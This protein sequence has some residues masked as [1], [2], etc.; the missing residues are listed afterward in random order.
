MAVST[1]K[2]S[3]GDVVKHRHFNFR[4]VIYDVDFEFN[5]S[6][7]WYRS[8]PKDV[9]PRKDQPFYHLLAENNDI[10][11]ERDAFY[12][13]SKIYEREGNLTAAYNNFKAYEGLKEKTDNANTA[14]Q[15][16]RLESRLAIELKEKE[17]QIL[18]LNQE[19][20]K[21]V[22]R[23]QRALNYAL[24]VIVLLVLL[25]LVMLFFTA[26]KRRRQNR[27]LLLKN[28]QIEEQQLKITN[29]NKE[30]NFWEFSSIL[31]WTGFKPVINHVAY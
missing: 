1:A 24:I 10:T 27:L 25:M 11:F 21:E 3:I 22:I 16:E 6:E 12:Y 26:R 29:Q 15:I 14:R 8:I 9:R 23:K 28:K 2:F 7:E 20:Y 4:G 5:N 31:F 17:N 13:L 19:A 18:V 30:I